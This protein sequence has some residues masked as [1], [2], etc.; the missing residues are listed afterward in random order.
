MRRIDYGGNPE[1]LDDILAKTWVGQLGIT[2]PA[3]YPRVVPVNF[4]WYNG[5]VY[6]HGASAGEKLVERGAPFDL[7]TAEEM[8]KIPTNH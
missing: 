5:A 1:D 7:V 3:G 6:F 2:D 8:R 4:A